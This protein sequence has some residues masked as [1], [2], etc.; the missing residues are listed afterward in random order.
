MADCGGQTEDDGDGESVPIA[1]HKLQAC[2]P[3]ATAMR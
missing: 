3:T 1:A 2:G